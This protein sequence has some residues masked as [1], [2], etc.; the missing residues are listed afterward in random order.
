MLFELLLFM[1][2]FGCLIV[3]LSL[4]NDTDAWPSDSMILCTHLIVYE[5]WEIL[6]PVKWDSHLMGTDVDSQAVP[7][8]GGGGTTVP[9]MPCGTLKRQCCNKSSHWLG[10]ESTRAE[11]FYL[12]WLDI[13]PKWLDLTRVTCEMT[14]TWLWLELW[15]MTRVITSWLEKW[16][17]RTWFS[18]WIMWSCEPWLCPHLILGEKI[19]WIATWSTPSWSTTHFV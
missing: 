18:M 7:M 4:A 1:F 16:H 8:G 3:L 2:C 13:S 15:Q 19:W 12:T 11:I 5:V 9:Q 14:L 6:P 10:L 17:T